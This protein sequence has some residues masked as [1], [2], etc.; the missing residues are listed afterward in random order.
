MAVD[1]VHINGRR[2]RV[3]ERIILLDF[4]D[5]ISGTSAELVVLFSGILAWWET[6]GLLQLR[7]WLEVIFTSDLIELFGGDCSSS[8][9]WYR[10]S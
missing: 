4:W 9:S 5:K 6:N 8:W 10:R 3:P 2:Y 7:G 1:E